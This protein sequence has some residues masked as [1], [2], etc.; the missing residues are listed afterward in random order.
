LTPR[1][2]NNLEVYDQEVLAIADALRE[3]NGP[4]DLDLSCG[5]AVNNE[6]WF[7]VC[8]YLKTHPALE[9]LH[10]SNGF[11]VAP[12]ALL[13]ML[14]SWIQALVDILKVNT[15]IHTI[16]SHCRCSQHELFRGLVISY[17]ETN[18]LRPHILA[19]QKIRPIPYRAKILG[20][21]LLAA[22]NDAIG[23]WM[24]LS[25]NAEVA[26]PSTTA[27]TTPAAN[28]PTPATAAAT[29]NVARV[30]ATTSATA[31]YSSNV[32]VPITGQKRKACP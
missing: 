29:E 4:V 21:A 20:R 10:L 27:T 2:S 22:R 30:I 19:I 13:A 15:S 3:N 7:A 14:E 11:G 31:T 16:H 23:F 6:T 25:G 28:L 5:A 32:A 8:D 18:R 1:L 24:L 26:F 17:L 12:L 9:V